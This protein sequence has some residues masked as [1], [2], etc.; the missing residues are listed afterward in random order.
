MRTRG[1]LL[2]A[3]LTAEAK[4]IWARAGIVRRRSAAN[5]RAVRS[6]VGRD[7]GDGVIYEE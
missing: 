7:G 3:R 6:D 1:L 2:R 5:A 4:V